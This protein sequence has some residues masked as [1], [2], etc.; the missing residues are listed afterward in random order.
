MALPPW[1]YG[2]LRARE[3]DLSAKNDLMD[4]SSQVFQMVLKRR[5]K[6]VHPVRSTEKELERTSRHHILQPHWDDNDR[7]IDRPFHFASD[8][9]R[10]VCLLREQQEHDPGLFDR[11]DDRFAPV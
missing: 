5:R 11:G 7:S 6:S 3:R 2:R 10:T 4:R 8:L 9:G 1:S